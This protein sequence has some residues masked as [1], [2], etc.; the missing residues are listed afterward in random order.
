MTCMMH[1][2]VIPASLI[3]PVETDPPQ[4]MSCPCTR[5]T[6]GYAWQA[7]CSLPREAETAMHV[8]TPL[9]ACALGI[10]T[11]ASQHSLNLLARR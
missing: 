8:A 6:I 2:D 7:T 11:P 1:A 10:D 5:N 3:P 4:Q 9:G